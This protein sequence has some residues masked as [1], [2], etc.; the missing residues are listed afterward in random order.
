MLV[1]TAISVD[2]VLGLFSRGHGIKVRLWDLRLNVLQIYGCLVIFF[3][4]LGI[5]CLLNTLTVQIDFVFIPHNRP[6]DVGGG[7]NGIGELRV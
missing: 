2:S 1:A 3:A 4:C 6:L 5:A 7:R